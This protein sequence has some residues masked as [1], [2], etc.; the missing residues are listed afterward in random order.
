M[1]RRV[2]LLLSVGV[3]LGGLT[4]PAALAITR[5]DPLDSG[6]RIDI[7]LIRFVED[8]EDIGN[9]TIRAHAGWRCR[10][11]RPAAKTALKWLFDGS[12]NN[13][14]DLVGS[15]TCRDGKL[16]FKLRSTDGNNEYEPIRARKLN[17]RTVKVKMPLELVEL[18][19][20]HLH[21]VARSKDASGETCNEDCL[22]RAPNS[23][24]LRAY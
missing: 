2:T 4:T 24:R 11:L 17:P 12:G 20:Q 14:F 21:L 22:D 5:E 8:P 7:A 15:F 19:S 1:R 23:G 6:L 3:L 9:L 13:D 16:L 18:D 10:D